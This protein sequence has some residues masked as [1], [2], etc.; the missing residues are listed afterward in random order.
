MVLVFHLGFFTV[1]PSIPPRGAS[2]A[3]AELSITTFDFT[4]TLNCLYS[5][6]F[7]EGE[8]SQQFFSFVKG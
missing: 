2:F 8:F 7:A 5:T 1:P 3:A 4:F 6:S